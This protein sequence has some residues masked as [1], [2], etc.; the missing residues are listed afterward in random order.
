MDETE[1]SFIF[2]I[3]KKSSCRS[4]I[5][6]PWVC[7]LNVTIHVKTV[8]ARKAWKYDL[9]PITGTQLHRFTILSMQLYIVWSLSTRSIDCGLEYIGL[10]TV[11]ASLFKEWMD[12]EH[13]ENNIYVYFR[14]F[15]I[16]HTARREYSSSSSSSL[17]QHQ[18]ACPCEC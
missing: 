4:L 11:Y 14:L 10:D 18:Q 7:E 5:P 1:S 17:H 6:G 16:S 12:N 8:I 2:S 9:R 15:H 3:S 13:I